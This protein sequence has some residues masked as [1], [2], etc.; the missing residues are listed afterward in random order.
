MVHCLNCLYELR[1]NV[2]IDFFIRS[3]ATSQQPFERIRSFGPVKVGTR[4]KIWKPSADI[5]DDVGGLHINLSFARFSVRE[6]THIDLLST[7]IPIEW[8]LRHCSA[9]E[10]EHH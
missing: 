2:T 9:K 5:G 7:G 4:R 1:A 10:N 8:K 3:D 6:H